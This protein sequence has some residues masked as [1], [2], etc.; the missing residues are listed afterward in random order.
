MST[1]RAF[2]ASSLAV[3]AIPLVTRA[4]SAPEL[5]P[6]IV[7]DLSGE[8]DNLTPALSYSTRDWSVMHSIY[9]S[10]VDF[11]PDGQILP[12]AAE[13]FES[14]DAITFRIKLRAGM[15]FHD[16]TPVTTAAI[17]R[18][19][20]HIKS[21][22]SQISDL[23]QVITEVRE[24]DDLTAEIICAQPS[25]WL[26]SQLVVWGVL[27]PEG[28]TEESLASTPVGSGPYVFESW[29]QGS[30]VT[31][32]RNPNYHLG[33]PKGDPL[34]ERVVYRFVPEAT[35]RVADLTTGLAHIIDAVPKDQL[36]AVSDGGNVAVSSPVLATAFIRIATDA[37][38]FDD[39]RVCQAVNHAI[40]VQA[41]ADALVSPEAKRLASI[42]PDARGLGFDE[43]LAPFAYDQEKAK[44]LLSE[45]GYSDGFETEAQITA[46]SRTDVLEAVAEQLAAVGIKMNIV[47]SELATFNQDWSNTDAPPLRYAS[48]RPMYDPF[49]FVNLLVSSKGYLSRYNNPSAD[50]L[51]SS[52]A[53]EPDVESRDATYQELGH[54]LQ[55]QPGFIY[56]W[57][58]VTN[59]GVSSAIDGWSPRGDDYVLALRRTQ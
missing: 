32:V 30:A 51:I 4:Q 11:A 17:T 18:N 19:V 42:F 29:D 12:Q 36:G 23:Y 40:D 52:A 15:T 34:A 43:T 1:R 8:P 39:P 35:T 46:T 58:L 6:E 13:S 24:I 47:T 59:V 7:I 45:A 21:A 48:W 9:D 31:L 57:N 55:E 2:V 37:A 44:A 25:P 10:L 54:A 33:S 56:L 20:E 50:E 27:L 3:A 28:F 49:T 22:E 14:D 38:P 16:G 53:V 41:I 5:L 26:P